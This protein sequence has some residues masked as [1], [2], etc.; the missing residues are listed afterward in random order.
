MT[1]AHICCPGP[2]LTYDWLDEHTDGTIYTV[3][4]ALQIAP[5]CDWWVTHDNPNRIHELCLP[6]ARELDVRLVVAGHRNRSRLWR[7]FGF[8]GPIEEMDVERSREMQG[9]YKTNYSTCLAIA[10]A[11][12]EGARRLEF[13]GVTMEGV[14]YFGGQNPRPKYHAPGEERAWTKRWESK[15]VNVMRAVYRYLVSNNVEAIGLPAKVT[16]GGPSEDPDED[17]VDPPQHWPE[18][19]V[20]R[21]EVGEDGQIAFEE[22]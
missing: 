19:M 20:H 18:H 14:G 13:H 1:T 22:K 7:K 21:F 15:E 16:E 8:D 4:L 9:P 5:R 2:T 12:K 17:E 11:L 3:N 10:H 6:Q